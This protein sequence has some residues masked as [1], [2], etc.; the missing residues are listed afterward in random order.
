MERKEIV[1]R[2]G[3]YLGIKPKYL[4]APSFAYQVGDYSV[5]RE[6]RIKNESGDEVNL[7]AIISNNLETTDLEIALPMKDHTGS[8]LKNL[9][10]MI[11]S[12]QFLIEE[13]A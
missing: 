5:D 2:L 1:K 4:G 9:V 7:E 8:T 3:E 12:R 6:G 11:Y 13:I 10:N